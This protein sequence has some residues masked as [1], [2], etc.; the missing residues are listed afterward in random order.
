MS[1]RSQAFEGSKECQAVG[2]RAA[3]FSGVEEETKVVRTKLL[4]A[5]GG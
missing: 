2:D 5:D 1:S 4:A 3:G